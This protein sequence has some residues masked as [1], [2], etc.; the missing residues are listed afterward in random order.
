MKSWPDTD[1][2]VQRRARAMLQHQRVLAEAAEIDR[3]GR[4]A[5]NRAAAAA[6]TVFAR[7]GPHALRVRA[8]LV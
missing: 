2:I 5:R 1:E 6:A 8:R 7:P 4:Q 3:L